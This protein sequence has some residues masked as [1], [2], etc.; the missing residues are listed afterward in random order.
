MNNLNE[1][2]MYHI[3]TLVSDQHLSN[4]TERKIKG[5]KFISNIYRTRIDHVIL[6]KAAPPAQIGKFAEIELLI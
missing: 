1:V 6:K 4:L 2:I 3:A 5:D